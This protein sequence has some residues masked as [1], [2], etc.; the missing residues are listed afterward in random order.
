MPYIRLKDMTN[1]FYKTVGEG[2]TIL[3]IHGFAADHNAFRF[4]EKIL[5][6]EYKIIS[7][8]LRSHGKSDKKKELNI[9]LLGRDLNEIISKLKLKDFSIL[10]WSMGGSVAFEYIK[11]SG[12][13]KIKNLILVETC[14]R[15][16]NDQYWD[17]GLYKGKYKIEN[18]ES[19]LQKIEE[20]YKEWVKDF[21]KKM[22]PSLTKGDLEVSQGLMETVDKQ[23]IK[24]LWESLCQCDYLDIAGTI[25][26]PTL[27]I[28]GEKSQFYSLRSAEKMGNLINKSKVKIIT[29]SG[30][31][32]PLEKPTEFNKTIGTFIANKISDL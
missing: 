5:G 31:L 11:I 24:S 21:V 30:H 6:K 14:L 16:L 7:I 17:Y 28:N 22:G 27:I 3:C 23:S 8:D 9:Q 15:I 18:L 10:A 4:T 26:I 20:N 12:T 19:D 13:K 29:N 2:S 25:D 1:I 32:V